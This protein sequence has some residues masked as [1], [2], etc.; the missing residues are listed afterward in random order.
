MSELLNALMSPGSMNQN[1][2][3][4]LGIVAFIV[5]ASFYFIYKLI[6]IFKDI[7]KSNYKPNIGLSRTRQWSGSAP[8]E[9]A[10]SSEKSEPELKAPE[11]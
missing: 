7:G 5:V 3:L 6:L 9:N 4:I 1:Q 11:E 8:K 2:W 10:V